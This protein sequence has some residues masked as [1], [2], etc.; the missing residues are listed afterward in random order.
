LVSLTLSGNPWTCRCDFFNSFQEFLRGDAVADVESVECRLDGGST[1]TVRHNTTCTDALAVTLPSDHTL[2]HIV[3]I[4]V[5]VVALCV[6][7]AVASVIV[8]VFRCGFLWLPRRWIF[9]I[10]FIFLFSLPL[11]HSGS[12]QVCVLL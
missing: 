11:S 9:L 8:F 1:L 10:L 7:V 6:V 3:P 12:P 5:S 2:N 4:A